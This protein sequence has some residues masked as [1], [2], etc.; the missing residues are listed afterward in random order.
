MPVRCSERRIGPGDRVGSANY[1]APM[2]SP[3]PISRRTLLAGLAPLVV[4]AC[5]RSSRRSADTVAPATQAPGSTGN[6]TGET[7]ADTSTTGATT[8]VD[9]YFPPD[10]GEWETVRAAAAGY[11]EAGLAALLEMVGAAN[12]ASFVLLADGRIVAPGDAP[13]A[14]HVA[15]L[16]LDG[17]V[18]QDAADGGR[19]P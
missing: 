2:S 18:A 1:A 6:T 13:P 10:S 4:V 14:V 11:T 19:H 5:D 12:S 15:S 3:S 7:G 9:G 17:P 8:S 16:V